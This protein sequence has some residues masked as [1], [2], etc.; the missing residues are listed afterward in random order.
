MDKIKRPRF[1]RVVSGA[2]RLNTG[3]ET[4]TLSQLNINLLSFQMSGSEPSSMADSPWHNVLHSQCFEALSEPA[5]TLE[6][7]R[8]S[9]PIVIGKTDCVTIQPCSSYN[10][11]DRY[12]V[13][14]FELTNGKWHFAAVFDGTGFR[15]AS[16]L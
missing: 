10:N 15:A 4:N 12:I 14:D 1:P 7:M 2:G 11:E 5:L 6:L 13:Q 3:E 16:P 9:S 8:L